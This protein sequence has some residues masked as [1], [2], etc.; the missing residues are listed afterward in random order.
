MTCFFVHLS[1]GE[2]NDRLCVG[3]SVYIQD[4]GS[5]DGLCVGYFTY[6]LVT[7]EDIPP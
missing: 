5:N 7:S 1:G 4:F 2:I 3:I 6:N